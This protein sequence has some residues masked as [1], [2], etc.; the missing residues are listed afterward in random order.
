MDELKIRSK[1]LK[2]ALDN[3]INKAIKKNF[4]GC[5]RVEPININDVC[6]TS[7]ETNEMYDVNIRLKVH[8]VFIS[9]LISK[10]F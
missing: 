3:I 8:K 9:E 2:H 1:F 10:F 5:E 4:S 7:D 6:I